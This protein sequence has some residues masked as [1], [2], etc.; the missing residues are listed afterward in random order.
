[1][2]CDAWLRGILGVFGPEVAGIVHTTKRRFMSTGETV[3]L[4]DIPTKII[5]LSGIH[6]YPLQTSF[7]FSS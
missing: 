4:S 5:A 1:M 3:Q 7:H 6:R 2:D